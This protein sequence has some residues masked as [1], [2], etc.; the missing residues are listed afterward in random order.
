MPEGYAKLIP[1]PPVPHYK[2]SMEGAGKSSPHRGKSTL[3]YTLHYNYLYFDKNKITKLYP[4]TRT[5]CPRILLRSAGQ[6]GTV[7]FG[8]IVRFGGVF[9]VGFGFAFAFTLSCYTQHTFRMDAV[10]SFLPSLPSV[11]SQF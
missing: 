3:L 11:L 1:K 5:L 6:L 9:V 2:Y 10:G 4:T 7:R 8:W